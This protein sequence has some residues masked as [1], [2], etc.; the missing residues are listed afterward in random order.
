MSKPRWEIKYEKYLSEEP[1]SEKIKSLKNEITG[2]T[3]GNYK[4]KAEFDKADSERRKN[5]L[6]LQ[7]KL[8][9]Y[10]NFEKNKDKIK[11]ILEYRKKLEEKLSELPKDKS[12]LIEQGRTYLKDK[13]E[14]LTISGITCNNLMEEIAELNSKLKT[15]KDED[16]PK[17]T[18]ELHKKREDLGKTQDKQNELME[19]I[20]AA[21]KL[22][23][24]LENEQKLF[25][26][27]VIDKKAMYERK[28]AK[29]NILAANLLKG[30]EI[31]NIELSVDAKGKIYTAKGEEAKKAKKIR[32]N[33]KSMEVDPKTLE[34]KNK[35]KNS[36][37]AE[38][39]NKE[40]D[41][42]K[43]LTAIKDFAERHPRLVKIGNFFKN[44]KD[45]VVGFFKGSDKPELVNIDKEPDEREEN[46]FLKS[47][48][49]N[50]LEATQ[51]AKLEAIKQK[52]ANE[53][54]E[55]YGGQYEKQDGATAKKKEP[56]GIEK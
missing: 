47:V 43:G 45:K 27:S 4:T 6:E 52:A 12:K 21:Q 36:K 39:K 53:Y 23:E 20:P 7:K 16:K 22:L 37:E 2:G 3:E 46:E 11:N 10:E 26:E 17:I 42:E 31:E 24:K 18:E 44:L 50:G 28:I 49:I 34:V 5:K 13:K 54:A 48:A 55:K 51:K 30:K 56:D 35:G 8:E 33:S 40:E 38:G 25:S 15:A 19:K 9:G 41:N 32:E 29:C 1:V 14:E